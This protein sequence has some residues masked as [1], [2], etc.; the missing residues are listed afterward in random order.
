M[1]PEEGRYR[2]TAA[3]PCPTSFGEWLRFYS[4]ADEAIAEK[5]G[6]AES[7]TVAEQCRAARRLA[8]R[9]HAHYQTRRAEEVAR[10]Y[11]VEV[12]R[13]RWPGVSGP[14]V[15]LA[16]SRLRPPQVRLN[17]QPIAKLAEWAFFVPD[18]LAEWL[19]EAQITNVIVAHELYHIIAE[20]HSRPAVEVAAHAF[21]REFTGLPFSPLLY[22]ALLRETVGS[23]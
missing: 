5:L 19:S 13:D 12:G 17:M 21:A 7:V 2:I 18:D 11:G 6:R 22:E 16:E 9:L 15:Y 23:Q 20:Q 10:A 3:Q 1:T 14:F 8:A 4:D